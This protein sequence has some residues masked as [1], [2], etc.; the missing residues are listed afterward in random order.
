MPSL[1]RLCAP[2][3]SPGELWPLFPRRG[4]FLV[5][6]GGHTCPFPIL[7]VN[8]SSGGCIN[9]IQNQ[10]NTQTHV[11]GVPLVAPTYISTEGAL[12]PR[13]RSAAGSLGGAQRFKIGQNPKFCLDRAWFRAVG[14]QWALRAYATRNGP[15]LGGLV[16]TGA[17]MGLEPNLVAG[18]RAFV[19][20]QGQT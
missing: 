5:P 4:G 17:Q 19:A 7:Y 13:F 9:P 20:Q 8:S 10:N 3:E 1:C 2:G 18:P 11:W 6:W 12:S 15:F 16:G 14:Y